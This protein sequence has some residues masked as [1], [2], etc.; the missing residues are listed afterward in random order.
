MSARGWEK[1]QHYEYETFT[2]AYDEIS[3]T[4][5]PYTTFSRYLTSARTRARQGILYDGV[6][7]PAGKEE[8]ERGKAGD[9]L[10]RPLS[11]EEREYCRWDWGRVG[12]GLRIYLS[13]LMEFVFVFFC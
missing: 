12:Y 7:C 1:K 5:R 6:G 11:R 4:I 9:G 2:A 3:Y 8:G 10:S 13:M